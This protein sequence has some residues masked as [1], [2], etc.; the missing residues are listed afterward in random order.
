MSMVMLGWKAGPEQY[1]PIDLLNQAIAAEKAGFE[2]INVSDHFHPWDPSGQSCNT[3]TWLGAAAAR[4]SGIEIGTGVTCPILRY[5]PAVIAQSAATVDRMNQGP[6]YLGLGTGEA[7]NEY[8][9]TGEW[10]SYDVRQDMMRESIELIRAL[11]TGREV[12]FD[13][14]YYTTRKARLYTGPRRG[15]PIFISSL[16]PESAYFAGYNGDG[17]VTGGNTPDV[18]REIADNFDDG[19]RDAGKDPSQMP[20]Q[21]EC[22][23]AYAEDEE[24]AIRYFKQYWAGTMVFAMYTQNLY[25]PEMSAINGAIAG[26]DT[27]KSHL[28]I[29]SDPEEHV[30]FAQRFI[31]IGFDR[32]CF[33][34]AG[35]DQIEFIEGYGRDVLPLIRRNRPAA[36][37]AS[38]IA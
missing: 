33:H 2:T 25:T 17:L 12:T 29:S 38:G 22:F 18:L 34:C 23:V 19:A 16:V 4:L 24:A 37:P 20:K 1:D 6:V 10:P 26:V 15:I 8:S 35:P 31:D 14:N 27:I 9:S 30:K 21:I 5:H 7:L 13:G 28:C 32:V 3:W 11:W 36:V